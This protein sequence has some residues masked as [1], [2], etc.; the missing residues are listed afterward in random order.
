[1]PDENGG[2]APLPAYKDKTIVLTLPGD[3]TVYDIDYLSVWCDE[4]SVDF[5]HVKIPKNLNV[6]PSLRMLGVAPQVSFSSSTSFLSKN[7]SHLT[8]YI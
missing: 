2:T 8:Q 7:N 3:L 5:G 1:V 6:P 4:Y